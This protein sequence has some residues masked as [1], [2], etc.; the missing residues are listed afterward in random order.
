MRNN[1][2]KRPVSQPAARLIEARRNN[3]FIIESAASICAADAGVY[4]PAHQVLAGNSTHL[5]PLV[6]GRRHKYRYSGQTI[7]AHVKRRLMP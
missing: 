5:S 7:R 4:S 2:Q 1:S 3:D 6:A